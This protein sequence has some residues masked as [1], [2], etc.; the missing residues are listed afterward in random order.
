MISPNL[1]IVANLVLKGQQTQK[2][3]DPI[4]SF[5]EKLDQTRTTRSTMDLFDVDRGGWTVPWLLQLI[6]TIA[7][8][9]RT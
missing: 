9:A 3:H 4:D 7:H 8:K 1:N 6:P 5:H 2:I